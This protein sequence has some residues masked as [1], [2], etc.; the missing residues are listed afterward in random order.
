MIVRKAS[1]AAILALGLGATGSLVGTSATTV[2]ADEPIVITGEVTRLEPGK[3]IVIRSSGKETTYTLSPSVVLPA[4]VQVGRSASLQL[5]V[6]AGGTQL[7]KTV[8]TTTVGPAGTTETTEVTR[9][10][11]P[12]G[13]M[14]TGTVETYV[15]G[16]SITVIDSKGARATYVLAPDAQ[17]PEE[18]I[19]GKKVTVLV[20]KDKPKAT[21]YVLER[22]GDQIKIK[23]K[24]ID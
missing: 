10:D 20:A 8:T 11:V 12:G 16:K 2:L 3:L 23:A 14:V 13:V 17:L 15:P 21:V 18:V 6:G 5:E 1:L 19:M 22:D 9:T 4:D 24:K 7:V